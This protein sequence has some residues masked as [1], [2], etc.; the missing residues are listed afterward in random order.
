MTTQ[1]FPVL[2][3]F[4]RRMGDGYAG[5]P[6]RA[7]IAA[8]ITEGNRT[9]ILTGTTDV[10]V[11]QA[12]MYDALPLVFDANGHTPVKA[13]DGTFTAA[14]FAGFVPYYELEQINEEH[15]PLNSTT[16]GRHELTNPGGYQPGES[17]VRNINVERW[18]ETNLT[19]AAPPTATD[20]VRILAGGIV[21]N[22][23]GTVVPGL[24][25]TGEIALDGVNNKV[26]TVVKIDVE[27]VA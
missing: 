24:R 16:V 18:I 8:L 23:G 22:A 6:R 2:G 5:K 26:Y 9:S 12:V 19:V 25:F 15:T 3:R 14:H 4:Q 20:A 21:S 10:Q 17:L 11:G 1:F 7:E 13:V 27:P